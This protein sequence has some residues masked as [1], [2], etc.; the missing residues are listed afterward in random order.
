M[1]LTCEWETNVYGVYIFLRQ[2][3]FHILPHHGKLETDITLIH[4]CSHIVFV[5]HSDPY[6]DILISW[7]LAQQQKQLMDLDRAAERLT[8]IISKKFTHHCPILIVQVHS[9][10]WCGHLRVGP[11][12]MI[13]MI[14]GMS[15]LHHL[16]FASRQATWV[17]L[18]LRIALLTAI[19]MCV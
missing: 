12:S 17:S 19:S 9:L 7:W 15:C 4:A 3:R 1:I 18:I 2:D 16:A 13:D 6:T 14:V 11:P 5:N 8:K 10:L